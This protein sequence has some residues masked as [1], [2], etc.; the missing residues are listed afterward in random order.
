MEPIHNMGEFNQSESTI[1][2][3]LK[4][5]DHELLRQICCYEK[6]G[7]RECTIEEMK[8]QRLDISRMICH[9]QNSLMHWNSCN[10]RCKEENDF[11]L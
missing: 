9:S 6:L 5:A 11:S 4:M 3:G 8:K 10:K 7:G 2:I 1:I